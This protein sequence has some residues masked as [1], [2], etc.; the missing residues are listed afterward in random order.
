[1]DQINPKRVFLRVFITFAPNLPKKRI[2][3]PKQKKC[4]SPLILHI[5]ISLGTKFHFQNEKKKRILGR[6]MPK[7]AFSVKNRKSEHQH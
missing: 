2:P 6:N 4:T 7:S 3:S 5:P 1:M